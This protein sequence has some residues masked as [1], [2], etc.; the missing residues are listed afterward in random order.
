MRHNGAGDEGWVCDPG[1]AEK[2]GPRLRVTTAELKH[3]GIDL[4]VTRPDGT[5]A[6]GTHVHHPAIGVGA[7]CR[8][9]NFR[10]TGADKVP[11]AVTLFLDDAV[12]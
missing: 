12:D 4:S 3:E 8:G 11:Y 5:T 1:G 10:F 9:L 6:I 2:H 7:L